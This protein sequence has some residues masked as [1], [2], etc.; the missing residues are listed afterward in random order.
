VSTEKFSDVA[1]N[2]NKDGSEQNNAVSL[3]IHN[4]PVDTTLPTIIVGSDKTT[5]SNGQTAT[6]NFSLSEPSNDFSAADVNVIGGTLSNFQGS[7]TSYTATFTPSTGATSAAVAVSSN[8]FT[9]A[10][11]N[12]NQDGT[13][14]NNA[15]SMTIGNGNGT[16]STDITPPT[17]IVS[18]DKSTL[19]NTQTATMSFTLS[20]PSSDFSVA[21]VVVLGGTLS[22][23]QGSGTSYTATFTPASGATSAVV[24]VSSDAFRDGG[25]NDNKDGAD[26]NNAVTLM[27]SAAA[28]DPMPP[29]IAISSDKTT[30]TSAQT[31]TISFN[32]SEPSSD[33]TL[34]DVAVVGGTLSN[35]QGSETSYTATFTP[36]ASST[37]DSV[38]SVASQKFKDVAGNFNTDGSDAN[39]SIVI[40]TSIVQ[41]DT[42]PPTIAL[43]SDKESLAL[44]QTAMITFALSEPSID[45]TASDVSVTGGTLSNFQGNGSSYSALFTPAVNSLN[46]GS[47]SVSSNKFHDAAG[48]FNLDGTDAN[49]LLMMSVNTV[50]DDISPMLLLSSDK[51]NLTPG[52][53]AR[54]GFTLSENSTSFTLSDVT[55][56]GGTLSNFEGS[57]ATYSATFTPNP[58]A[59]SAALFVASNTFS[60]PA[61]NVNT[62]G[63][64]VDNA[65]SFSIQSSALNTAALLSSPAPA[66]M[67]MQLADPVNIFSINLTDVLSSST[68]IGSTQKML[69]IDGN[70]NDVVNLSNLLDSGQNTGAWQPNMSIQLDQQSYKY[71]THSGNQNAVL[72]VEDSIQT[73]NLM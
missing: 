38:I 64:D 18:S 51:L 47:V 35:F 43:S 39:N 28:V 50:V 29:T 71:W 5:L 42:T 67:T 2:L 21:D 3:T 55:V 72:L 62:D 30:L 1:G 6:I 25:G 61:G 73:L 54:I 4:T 10:A 9:D 48:N 69:K 60:D 11:G 33:F 66:L 17:I 63:S 57:G 15:V 20:E 7:G 36:S 49:N 56:V 58:G 68:T 14:P 31:A 70:A 22:N 27:I 53:T 34:A 46:N 32:L 41:L 19:S 37:V 12:Y 44:G 40:K 45:F 8:T 65:L 52:E 13:E 16:G 59:V 24:W 26:A 23:F